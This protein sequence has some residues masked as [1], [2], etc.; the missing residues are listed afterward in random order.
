MLGQR[1][2]PPGGR[3][4][5]GRRSGRRPP[6]RHLFLEPPRTRTGQAP[7]P[8][9][10]RGTPAPAA[11]ADLGREVGVTA[12]RRR[13]RPYA[14]T[15]LVWQPGAWPRAAGGRRSFARTW[16]VASMGRTSRLYET[17]HKSAQDRYAASAA[18]TRPRYPPTCTSAAFAP[19]WACSQHEQGG[20]QDCQRGD[21]HRVAVERGHEDPQGEDA[22]REKQQPEGVAHSASGTSLAKNSAKASR[23]SQSAPNMLNSTPANAS[24]VRRWT[25]PAISWTKPAR[26]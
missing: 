13:V 21:D 23:D 4:P 12:H 8:A 5:P 6:W 11:V 20:C 9:P 10:A 14:A 25:I 19:Y 3:L 7:R 26:T 24:P 1:P 2:E 15:L 17:W 22:E 16:L 18:A